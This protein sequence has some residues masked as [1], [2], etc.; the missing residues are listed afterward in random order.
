[1]SFAS[2]LCRTMVIKGG[3]KVIS[4]FVFPAFVLLVVA[5]IDA[6]AGMQKLH[7]PVARLLHHIQETLPGVTNQVA[8][9]HPV[10]SV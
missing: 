6:L 4:S 7:L 2:V 8:F 9:D 5:A 3:H 10:G 1:M